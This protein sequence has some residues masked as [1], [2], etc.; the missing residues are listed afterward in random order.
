MLWEIL[1]KKE[2]VRTVGGGRTGRHKETNSKRVGVVDKKRAG[3]REFKMK[4]RRDCGKQKVGEEKRRKE[5]TTAE[6][7]KLRELGSYPKS[8]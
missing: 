2:R 6:R 3:E 7:K 4:R 8:G 5:K 1:R